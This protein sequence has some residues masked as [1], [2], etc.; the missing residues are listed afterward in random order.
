MPA[1]D[2]LHAEFYQQFW[3]DVGNSVCNEVLDIFKYGKVLEYLNETL[4]TLIRSAK[5]PNL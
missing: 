4:I 1:L 2:G 3:G 5:A